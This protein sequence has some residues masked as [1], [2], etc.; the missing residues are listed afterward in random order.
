MNRNHLVHPV[1]NYTHELF[2]VDL[3][4]PFYVGQALKRFGQR[5]SVAV[6]LEPVGQT[7]AEELVR[8]MRHALADA[9]EPRS[10]ALCRAAILVGKKLDEAEETAPPYHN[11]AHSLLVMG[12]RLI[13]CR[14]GEVFRRR[15]NSSLQI[16]DDLRDLVAAMGLDLGHKGARGGEGKAY[17][18]GAL[19]KASFAMMQPL[20][21]EAGVTKK[22]RSFIFH[23]LYGTDPLLPGDALMSAYG[24]YS[25]GMLLCSLLDQI[26]DRIFF[27]SEAAD[28]KD[29]LD[30]V[31][32]LSEN[33]KLLRSA[34]ILKGCDMVPRFGLGQSFG[35]RQSR[36]LHQESSVPLVNEQGL[37]LPQQRLLTAFRF[38]GARLCGGEGAEACFPDPV[39][40]RL[41]GQNLRRAQRFC[42]QQLGPTATRDIH[43]GLR[44]QF[45][46]NRLL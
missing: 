14:A 42:E 8:Y 1:K 46:P 9:Q 19:E 20:L 44:A 18:P 33:K 29:V 10:E 31:R 24:F 36:Q 15:K 16:V 28:R 7:V 43:R 27:L 41:F 30:F 13:R 25:P 26:D 35:N 2:I 21:Q 5:V 32:I 22:D 4:R 11:R 37:P 23:S 38:V 34:M 12:A 45:F 3:D 40:D 6:P 39:L 17:R